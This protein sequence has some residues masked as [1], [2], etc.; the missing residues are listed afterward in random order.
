[1]AEEI[2]S[3]IESDQNERARLLMG[4]KLGEGLAAQVLSE[5]ERRG[6]AEVRDDRVVL[7]PPGETV[8]RMVIRRHRL[9]EVLLGHVLAVGEKDTESTACEVEH[10]LSAD[11]TDRICTFLG[12]PPV[13]PHGKEIPR[14][15][16]CATFQR[17][18]TPL[19]Q[20]L[21]DL[22]IGGSGR[23]VFMTPTLHRRLDRLLA[24][25]F[26]PGGV[27]RLHQRL[28]SFVVQVGETSVAL[29]PE[30]CREVFVLPLES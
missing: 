2:W 6:M 23:I 26:K 10:I 4:S 24:L 16:C 17:E 5:M 8:A 30:I 28:P 13:C 11:V 7:L 27:I 22:A 3:L 14:G 1:M 9:A 21:S 18:V 20:P 29:D 15:D 19:V 12:H 25:G